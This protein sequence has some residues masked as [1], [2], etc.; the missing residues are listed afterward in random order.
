MNYLLRTYG[1]VENIAGTEDKIN[2]FIQLPNKTPSQ[3]AEE[4]VVKMLR[5]KDVYNT[6]D[7]NKILIK[8]LDESIM[9]SM[10]G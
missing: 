8:R 3:Y 4:L 10:R 9:Q 7:V 1:T 5:Y 2:K 6:Q